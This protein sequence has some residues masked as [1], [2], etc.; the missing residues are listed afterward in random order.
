VFE[1]VHGHER[2]SFAYAHTLI[3]L[4]AKLVADEIACLGMNPKYVARS[5]S[6]QKS[7]INNAQEINLRSSHSQK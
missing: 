6:L 2:R 7:T 4:T 1:A 5:A 3:E